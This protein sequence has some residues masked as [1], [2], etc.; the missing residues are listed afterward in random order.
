MGI[1][2]FLEK[3]ASKVPDYES[4]RG[5]LL[6]ENPDSE[7]LRGT[8]IMLGGVMIAGGFHYADPGIVVTG[9]GL[10]DMAIGVGR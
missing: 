5:Y 9:I 6:P 10:A 1:Y 2:D 7:I 3:Y 8:V 4:L